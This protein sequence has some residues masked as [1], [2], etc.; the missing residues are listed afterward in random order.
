MQFTSQFFKKLLTP[1]YLQLLVFSM[2]IANMRLSKFK[3]NKEVDL[4][5]LMWLLILV[6]L[7]LLE[8]TSI[9][10]YLVREYCYCLTYWKLTNIY[11]YYYIYSYTWYILQEQTLEQINQ[12][13]KTQIDWDNLKK[14]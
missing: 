8:I 12:V 6:D 11:Y 9:S 4:Y 1:S 7:S 14:K 5:C 10:S 13:K 2:W 3:K